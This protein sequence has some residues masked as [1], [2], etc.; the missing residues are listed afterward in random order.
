M[1]ITNK[2]NSVEDAVKAFTKRETLG[3]GNEWMCDGCKKKV[4]ATKQM[5]ISTPPAVLV[6]H[7]K[8]VSF[9]NAFSK[10][11]KHISFDKN[12]VLP[13]SHP[14]RKVPYELFGVVV[15]TGGSVSSGHYIALVRSA[16]GQWLQMNDESVSHISAPDIL[17]QQAYILFYRQTA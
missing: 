3:K 5:T 13:C 8:R 6:L 7:L 15:H 14:K 16:N 10:V 4:V 17:K 12:L 11:K 9:M 1:E 2:V